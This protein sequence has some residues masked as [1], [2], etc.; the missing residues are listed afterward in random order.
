MVL[1]HGFTQTAESWARVAGR[2]GGRYRVVRVDAPGHGASSEVQADLWTGGRL[3]GEAGGRAAYVGYSMGGRLCLHLALAAP[4]TV[5]ALVLVG[6]T[7]GIEDPGERADRRA[8]DEMLARRL[9]E[10]GLEVFL[11]RWLAQPLFAR[12]HPDAAD[13]SARRQN[14]VSGLAGSLRGAGSGT[15]EPLWRRLP[16]LAMPVL[17]V[18]GERDDKFRA[19]GERLASGIG[20]NATLALVPGAGHAAHLEAPEAF[21]DVIEPFLAAHV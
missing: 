21:L 1:V 6:A 3:V 15:Q 14:T 9:E 12:L 18:A 8:Q 19:L 4:A 10:D 17:V 7:A 16:D 2:L 5:R 11:E 13:L 20:P